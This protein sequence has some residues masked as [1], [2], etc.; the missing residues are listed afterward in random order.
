MTLRYVDPIDLHDAWNTIV[1][2]IEN[3]YQEQSDGWMPEDVYSC[4]RAGTSTL[5]LAYNDD[6][7]GFVVLTLQ[8]HFHGKVLHIWCGFGVGNSMAER[9]LPEIEIM[10]KQMGAKEITLSSKRRGWAKYLS[11]GM[12][13]YRKDVA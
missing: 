4:L 8:Q 6:Y 1:P 9:Y 13:M 12:T 10:A 3:L 2:E 7:E 5:H 11:P